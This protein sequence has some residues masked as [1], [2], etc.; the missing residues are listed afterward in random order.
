MKDH[1][2][3]GRIFSEYNWG[4]YLIWKLPE[5]KVFID[6]RMPSWRWKDNP[7]GELGAAFDDYSDILSGDKDYKGMFTKYNVD[8][9]LTYIPRKPSVFDYWQAYLDKFLAQFG[10]EER[11]FDFLTELKK[12]G[13]IEVY[14]DSVAVIYK[15]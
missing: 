11:S 7:E 6:G 5:K 4:G 12:D 2:P 9:V 8:T 10:R 3:A 14:R 13:W 1:L 15:K